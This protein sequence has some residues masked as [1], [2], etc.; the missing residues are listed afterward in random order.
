V[1]ADPGALLQGYL[2]GELDPADHDRFESWVAMDDARSLTVAA[3]R[4]SQDDDGGMLSLDE[5][6]IEAWWARCLERMRTPGGQLAAGAVDLPENGRELRIGVPAAGAIRWWQVPVPW[7]ALAASILCALLG[8][9]A[10]HFAHI[11]PASHAAVTEH[12]YTTARGERAVVTLDGATVI[13]GPESVL[14]ISGSYGVRGRTVSLTGHGYFDVTPD[15]EHPFRVWAKGILTEDI[16]TRFDLRAY[17]RDLATRLVVAEGSVAMRTNTGA[18]QTAPVLLTRGMMATAGADGVV[19]VRS[20][21]AADRY[22]AWSDGRLT[23]EDTPLP[24]AVAEIGRWY[25]LDI[26]LGDPRLASKT[27]TATFDDPPAAVLVALE[28]ALSVRAIR[29]GRVVTLYPP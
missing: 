22:V 13:L 5:A 17:P 26:R 25:D 11:N 28:A 7:A 21:V 27:L 19:R 14:R 3:L 4:Y 16:G 1:D 9:W 20:A 12:A 8:L 10:L 2:V 15:G 23:F 29:V 24:E 18:L 6:D